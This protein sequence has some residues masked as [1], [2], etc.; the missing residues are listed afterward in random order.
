MLLRG[1]LDTSDAKRHLRTLFAI[2][3]RSLEESPVSVDVGVGSV[4]KG[5]F[6][7]PNQHRQYSLINTVSIP[8][9]S[10]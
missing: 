2:N 8:P 3:G 5:E 6:V 1:C 7:I 10:S 9:I 4:P